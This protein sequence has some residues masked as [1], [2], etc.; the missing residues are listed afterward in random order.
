MTT[1]PVNPP[2]RSRPF[3]RTV[4]TVILHATAGGSA[5][6]AIRH[7]REIGF[8]YH[9]IIEKNGTV[10]KGC[11]ASHMTFHAGASEGPS[12]RSCNLY[13]IGIAFV[14]LNDGRDPYTAEQL[15]AARGIVRSITV[16]HPVRWITTHAIVS[17]GRKTD[18]RGF[19]LNAF[20]SSVSLQPWLGQRS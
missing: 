2:F 1:I 9:Y 7:L 11:P 18:P 8:G 16:Q 19:D 4:D 20:G 5:S 17:P 12:G 3:T 6:G 13:S 15:A 10:H 14:N